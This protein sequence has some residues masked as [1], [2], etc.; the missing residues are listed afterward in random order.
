MLN[1]PLATDFV[2][3]G[4]NVP[5]GGPDPVS[6]SYFD[7]D[8]NRPG[9]AALATAYFNNT[10]LQGNW[11]NAPGSGGEPGIR[12]VPWWGQPGAETFSESLV[13]RNV[14]GGVPEPATWAMMLIGFAGLGYAARRRKEA[15]AA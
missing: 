4:A 7:F 14:A 8:S 2:F 10:F 9:A 15:L 13:V 12:L 6:G 1:A 3:F 5:L 11:G